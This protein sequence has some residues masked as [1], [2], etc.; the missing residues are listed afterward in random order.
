MRK[1]I[2]AVAIALTIEIETEPY[3]ASIFKRYVPYAQYRNS[4]A[5]NPINGA[6]F[7]FKTS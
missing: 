7:D 2:L 4:D 6:I 5:F 1:R 3:V